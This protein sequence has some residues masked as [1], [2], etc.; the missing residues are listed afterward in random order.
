[1]AGDINRQNN[2]MTRQMNT[3]MSDIYKAFAGY[4]PKWFDAGQ[5]AFTMNA[6][7]GVE[8][9]G[10]M[11]QKQGNMHFANQ[12]LLNS[13][14]QTGF[15]QGLSGMLN[16]QRMGVANDAI[17]YRQMLQNLI[18]QERANMQGQL[19]TAGV[20]GQMSQQFLNQMS[21]LGTPSMMGQL[22]QGL[23]SI[24][25]GASMGFGAK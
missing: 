8:Q 11:A 23:S 16:Q 21:N 25:G 19:H 2:E 24:V 6:L 17:G 5:K 22:G 18:E 9:Q 7:P 20:P 15:N 3:G 10:L 4:T 1:M 13:S 14:A 12:G